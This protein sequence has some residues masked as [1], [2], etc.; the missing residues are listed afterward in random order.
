MYGTN[1]G[2][3]LSVTKYYS[4]RRIFT[5]N[6]DYK[7]ML[8]QKPVHGFYSSLIH[9]CQNAE[10]TKVSFNRRMDKQWHIHIMEYYS[11]I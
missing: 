2:T 6:G 8:I 4:N 5:L 3:E 11:M 1:H 9:N 10:A 7:L